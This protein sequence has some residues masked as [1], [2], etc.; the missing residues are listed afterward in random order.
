MRWECNSIQGVL[1]WHTEQNRKD[2]VLSMNKQE[3]VSTDDLLDKINEL[4]SEF[5]KFRTA[6]YEEIAVLRSDIAELKLANAKI[7][8]DLEVIW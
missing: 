8:K 6:A 3:I 7:N 1:K 5:Y 2:W 4:Q